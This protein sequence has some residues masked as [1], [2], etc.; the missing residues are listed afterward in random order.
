MHGVYLGGGDGQHVLWYQPLAEDEEGG[1]A[2]GGGDG[3][4]GGGDGVG[5][6]DVGAGGG[7]GGGGGGGAGAGVWAALRYGSFASFEGRGDDVAVFV[8]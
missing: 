2:G 3:D 1:R 8:V 6:E 5:S 7:T 4:G